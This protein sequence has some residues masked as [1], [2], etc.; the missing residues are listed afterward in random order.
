MLG[1]KGAVP[2]VLTKLPGEWRHHI[3]VSWPHAPVF[4]L[5]GNMLTTFIQGMCRSRGEIPKLDSKENYVELGKSIS[6]PCTQPPTEI[7]TD[8]ADWWK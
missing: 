6:V 8:C 7:S 1:Y 3:N 5:L 2:V 4:G